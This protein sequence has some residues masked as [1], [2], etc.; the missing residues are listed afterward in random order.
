MLFRRVEK[1]DLPYIYSW[2]SNNDYLRHGVLE[3]AFS[4][5]ILYG[6]EIEGKVE[7]VSILYPV[8]RIAWLMGARVR[9][10]VRGRGVGRYMTEKLLEEARRMGLAGAALLTSRGNIPIHRICSSLNME[11]LLELFS[12]SIPVLPPT[13]SVEVSRLVAMHPEDLEKTLKILEREYP[14]LPLTPG[15]LIWAPT[16][17]I[18]N[19]IHSKAYICRANATP[20]AL[21]YTGCSWVLEDR[22]RST[23]GAIL[24]NISSESPLQSIMSCISHL[25]YEEGFY[26]IVIWSKDSEDL[27]TRISPI[28]RWIWRSY[29]YYKDLR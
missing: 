13:S 28:A 29:I 20:L 22:C 18:I 3:S 9:E 4:H 24:L 11:K 5:G 2:L 21:V 14:L 26:D 6:V 10:M 16:R 19:S 1:K 7:A 15:G 8:D 17:Y 12:A 27:L 23:L 25:S